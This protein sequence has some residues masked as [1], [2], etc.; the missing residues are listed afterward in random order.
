MVH[1]VDFDRR[2]ERVSLGRCHLARCSLCGSFRDQLVGFRFRGLWT[3]AGRGFAGSCGADASIRHVKEEPSMEIC[4]NLLEDL[5]PFRND[6][7]GLSSA[8]VSQE[9]G[10][11]Q[12]PSLVWSAVPD[13][14]RSGSRQTQLSQ[15]RL[16][17]IS[18]QSIHRRDCFPGSQSY[19]D[20]HGVFAK[21]L[22]AG[23]SGCGWRAGMYV[24]GFWVHLHHHAD[25]EFVHYTGV[26]RAE[27]WT[28][29]TGSAGC[30]R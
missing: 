10:F 27:V 6:G 8:G 7:C 26:S 17:G 20:C 21:A 3:C 19:S 23:D 18:E 1:D 11:C 13:C 25:I 30:W 12:T 28:I 2:T 4:Q 14:V 22:L 9:S 24:L 15:C 5:P 29:Q 16:F